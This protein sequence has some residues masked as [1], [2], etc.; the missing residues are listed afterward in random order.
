MFHVPEE[1]RVTEGWLGSSRGYGNNGLHLWRPTDQE[2][3][4]PAPIL[5]GVK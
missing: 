4:L 5:V 2:I 3:P 1:C